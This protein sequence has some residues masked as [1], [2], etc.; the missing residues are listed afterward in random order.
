ME[1]KNGWLKV[2]TWEGDKWM[3]PNGELRFVNKSLYVYNE[4]SFSA[5]KEMVVINMMHRI[6][7]L[8]TEQRMVG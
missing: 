3:I 2:Q 8:S 6:S 5:V 7:T 1:Q 4:P